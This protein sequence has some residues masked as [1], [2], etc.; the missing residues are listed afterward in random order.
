MTRNSGDA[1]PGKRDA[2]KRSSGTR[3]RMPFRMQTPAD[4]EEGNTQR[5]LC[6]A[7]TM[8]SLIAL[9][10]FLPMIDIQF[11]PFTT[12]QAI[13]N[14][15]WGSDQNSFVPRLAHHVLFRSA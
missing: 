7:S 9:D 8:A 13:E 15:V 14:P 4:S 1:L 3:G 2:R 12:G 5:G 10:S 6:R 11:F